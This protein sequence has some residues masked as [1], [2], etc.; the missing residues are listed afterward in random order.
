M[1]KFS[2]W[3]E[4]VIERDGATSDTLEDEEFPTIDVAMV[5][6]AYVLVS[7]T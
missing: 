2:A 4:N 6:H 5:W 7:R 1:E 3:I